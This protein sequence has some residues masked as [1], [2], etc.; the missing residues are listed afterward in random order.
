M[1]QVVQLVCSNP[2]LLLRSPM[3]A[4][5]ALKAASAVLRVGLSETVVLAA[6]HPDLLLNSDELLK[7]SALSSRVLKEITSEVTS[8]GT[9]LD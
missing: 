1:S 6:Q 7:L 9:T 2:A 5:S 4:L 3:T 8:E